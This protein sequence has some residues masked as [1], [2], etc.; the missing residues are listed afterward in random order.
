MHR[1]EWISAAY[2][3]RVFNGQDGVILKNTSST[4]AFLPPRPPLFF[5]LVAAFT[6]YNYQEQKLHQ[7]GLS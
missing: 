7:S 5:S 6:E 1:S 3:M 2:K 4:S